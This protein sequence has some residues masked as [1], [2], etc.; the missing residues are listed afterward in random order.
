MVSGTVLQG[1]IEKARTGTEGLTR[2]KVVGVGGGGSNAVNRMI[3]EDIS[4]IDFIALN[5]DAQALVRSVAETR[6][7]IGDRLTKGLGAGG[8]HQLGML[9]A[10]ESREDIANAVADADMVFVTAG[11][12]GGTGTGGARSQRNSVP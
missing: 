4:G 2:I 5:T 6:L 1:L 11:M 7:R 9:A 3:E 10:D 12:G 8:D